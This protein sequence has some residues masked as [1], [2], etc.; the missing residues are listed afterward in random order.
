MLLYINMF[1]ILYILKKKY[2]YISHSF[3]NIKESKFISKDD[4]VI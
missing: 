3:F 2:L 4:K 1:F